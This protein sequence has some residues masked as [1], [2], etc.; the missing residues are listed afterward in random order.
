M[1]L[2]DTNLG[3]SI[4]NIDNTAHKIGWI[5]TI[6]IYAFFFLL[7]LG[8]VVYFN[9]ADIQGLRQDIT[10]NQTV[11]TQNTLQI[12][13]ESTP[14]LGTVKGDQDNMTSPTK[15][16]SKNDWIADEKF[17]E[18]KEGY[19]CRS[20]GFGKAT[21]PVW[22][23]WTKNTYK[24]ISP[25]HIT[26]Q[27]K[28]LEKLTQPPTISLSFGRYIKDYSPLPIYRLDLFDTDTRTVR[29][30]DANNDASGPAGRLSSEPNLN[31]DITISIDPKT[32]SNTDRTLHE[33]PVISYAL[34]DSPITQSDPLSNM[35][36]VIPSVDSSVEYQYG[37]GIHE[38]MC[39]KILSFGMGR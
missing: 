18:D 26:V 3:N 6:G 16:F 9:H 19:F 8:V 21:F 22:S 20:K 32:I 25:V 33:N 14:S 5:K 27:V 15:S 36:I 10:T 13:S 29:L 23:L 28:S 38:G 30:Y 24:L 34:P 12:N 1:G 4:K 35:N 2:E 17:F 7:P 11:N 37:L 31:S 39:I